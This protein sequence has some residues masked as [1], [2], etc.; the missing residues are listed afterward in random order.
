AELLD[1]DLIVQ[2]DRGVRSGLRSGTRAIVRLAVPEHAAARARRRGATGRITPSRAPRLLHLG[3]SVSGRGHVAGRVDPAGAQARGQRPAARAHGR[4]VERNRIA[5]VDD[6][7]L[8]TQEA[9]LP[10]LALERPL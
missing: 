1:L 9:D 6:V 2:C 8:G 5:E 7:E 3:G 10:S 4:D